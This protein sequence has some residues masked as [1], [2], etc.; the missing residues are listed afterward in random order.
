MP[1]EVFY[2]AKGDI[3]QKTG[4]FEDRGNTTPRML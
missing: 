1:G 4:H 3:S 2:G